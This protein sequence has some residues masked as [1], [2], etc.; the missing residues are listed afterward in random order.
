[1]CLTPHSARRTAAWIG[2]DQGVPML[3]TVESAMM[4]GGGRYWSVTGRPVAGASQPPDNLLGGSQRCGRSYGSATITH[5]RLAYP[6]MRRSTAKRAL[7][8]SGNPFQGDSK[9]SDTA[10][11]GTRGHGDMGARGHQGTY[12]LCTCLPHLHLSAMRPPCSH[13]TSRVHV[14][15]W[16]ALR[17]LLAVHLPTCSAPVCH[18]AAMQP[19]NKPCH[20]SR[21]H[22]H[23]D[24][25]P[26]VPVSPCPFTV[27]YG[28]VSHAFKSI[29][30]AVQ[31]QVSLKPVPSVL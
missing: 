28:P 11:P 23:S 10:F 5:W 15:P 3:D 31:A 9:P 13:L 14:S 21:C 26:R 30:P 22:A 19:C 18:A 4:Q 1:M 29:L 24:P 6:S 12:Q 16:P 2:R 20:V 25:C 8:V 17:D 7:G 27:T